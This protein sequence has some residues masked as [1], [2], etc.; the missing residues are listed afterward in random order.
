[1]LGH[2]KTWNIIT[3]PLPSP[4]PGSYNLSHPIRAR[5]TLPCPVLTYLLYLLYL[6]TSPYLLRLPLES[7][8]FPALH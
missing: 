5:P 1:M 6:Y 8:T 7:Y 4:Q 3:L 2:Y